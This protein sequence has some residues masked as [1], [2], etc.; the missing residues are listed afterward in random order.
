MSIISP[1]FYASFIR[2]Q[3]K[4]KAVGHLTCLSGKLTFAKKKFC[5]N[6]SYLQKITNLT[7]NWENKIVVR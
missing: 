4:K 3:P 2:K 6:I 5:I 1:S 7:N